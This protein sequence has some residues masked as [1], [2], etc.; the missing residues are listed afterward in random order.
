MKNSPLVPYVYDLISE[1]D[2]Y[3]LDWKLVAAISGVESN[4]GKQ[5]WT[6]SHNAW[7][8]GGGKITFKSWPKGIETISKGLKTGYIEKGARNPEQISVIYAPFSTTWAAKVRFFMRQL[9][10]SEVAVVN[11]LPMEWN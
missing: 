5:I 4:F 7:G 1:A 2:K 6:G 11:Q 10:I 9:E 8:W 3:G